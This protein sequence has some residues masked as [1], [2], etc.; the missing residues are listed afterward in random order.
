MAFL[1]I[2]GY[3]LF[4]DKSKRLCNEVISLHSKKY[5]ARLGE[6]PKQATKGKLQA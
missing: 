6:L 3:S 5:R 4:Y 2:P 1:C